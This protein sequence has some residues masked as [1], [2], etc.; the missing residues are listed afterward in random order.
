MSKSLV[1]VKK[2]SFEIINLLKSAEEENWSKIFENL[3]NK[4]ETTSEDEIIYYI[5][6]LYGGMGSFNDLVLYIGESPS[7]DE[8]ER[9]YKYEEV[10]LK[11]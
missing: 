11:R 3:I 1:E 7:I 5:E 9:L 2:I 4:Y 10:Y 8:N 6:S